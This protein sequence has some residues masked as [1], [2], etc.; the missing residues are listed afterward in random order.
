MT[1]AQTETVQFQINLETKKAIEDA[2]ARLNLTPSAYLTYLVERVKPGVDAQRLDRMVN[3]V[4][5]KFGP[6]MRALAK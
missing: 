5:G 6:A 1:A 3:E 4:F 2:A